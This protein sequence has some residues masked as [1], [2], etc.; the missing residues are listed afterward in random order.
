MKFNIS[1][2]IIFIG[3]VFGCLVFA[4]GI[5]VIGKFFYEVW[6]YLGNIS[7]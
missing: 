6:Q 7:I 3:I 5:I 4:L 2:A 1:D